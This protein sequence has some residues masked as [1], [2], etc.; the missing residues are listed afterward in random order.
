MVT[1]FPAQTP[2]RSFPTLSS[3]GFFPQ[4]FSAAPGTVEKTTA[5][6]DSK[7]FSEIEDSQAMP[8]IGPWQFQ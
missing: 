7:D 2:V 5:S 4:N 6:P 3:W 1:I 8:S